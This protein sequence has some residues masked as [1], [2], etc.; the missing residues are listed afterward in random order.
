MN[1]ALLFNCET[2]F[3]VLNNIEVTSI[4]VIFY[5]LQDYPGNKPFGGLVPFGIISPAV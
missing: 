3:L 2:V 5:I 4:L 1:I